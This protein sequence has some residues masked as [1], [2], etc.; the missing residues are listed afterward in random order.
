MICHRLVLSSLSLGGGLGVD[1]SVGSG[2]GSVG[3]GSSRSGGGGRVGEADSG[4]SS[5]LDG[6]LCR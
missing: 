3:S 4:V 2:G 1:S 6:E 5:L